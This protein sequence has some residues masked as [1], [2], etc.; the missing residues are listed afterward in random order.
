[1]ESEDEYS[2]VEEEGGG[3]GGARRRRRKKAGRLSHSYLSLGHLVSASKRG[4]RRRDA[5][6]AVVSVIV[7]FP[8]KALVVV[9]G[10]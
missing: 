5:T 6:E 9:A 10:L 7:T 3:G 2:D 1:M 8:A 4:K